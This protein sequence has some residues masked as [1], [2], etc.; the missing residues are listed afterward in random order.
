M[1]NQE[2]N[3]FEDGLES[4]DFVYIDDVVNATVSCLKSDKSGQHIL[5]VGSGVPVNVMEVA[6][7]IVS[8]LKSKSPIKIS[9]AFRQGD[10]RHNYADLALIRASIGFEP[11]WSFREGLHRFIDWALA[12]ND[13]PNDTTDYRRSLEELKQKGLLNG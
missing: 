12:Q 11:K 3:I 4:R 9:G 6:N 7:E 1:Q 8:Y 13:I 10:I 5:N 2:I